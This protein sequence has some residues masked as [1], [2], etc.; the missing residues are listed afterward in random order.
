MEKSRLRQ[1]YQ[2]LT[3]PAIAASPASNATTATTRTYIGELLFRGTTAWPSYTPFE[4]LSRDLSTFQPI[5]LVRRSWGSL[6]WYALALAVS[7]ACLLTFVASTQGLPDEGFALIGLLAA[8]AAL[9]E[10]QPVR[11][12]S[13][14]EMT[15]SVL[16]VLFA[17]VVFGPFAAMV[18]AGLGLL[19]EFRRPYLRWMIWTSLRMLGAGLAGL[20]ASLVLVDE[21]SFERL[22]AAA[23]IATTT[24]ALVDLSLGA[25]TVTI[26]RSGQSAEFI[27]SIRPILLA[28]ICLYTPVIVLLAYAYELSPWSLVLFLG[29]AFAAHRLYG[30]YRQEREATQQLAG[31]YT[32]LEEANLSFASALVAALD[33]RDRYTAGHSAAVAVYARDIARRLGLSDEDQQLAHLSGLLHDIGKVGLPAG[34]L[35]KAGPLTLHERRQMEEH[36]VIGERILS[37]V[38]DYGEIA[39]IVRYHHERIDGNGYPDGLLGA[40]IPVISKIIGVADAYNAMTSGRPYRDAMPSRVARMRLAQA[41]ETQFDTSVV[42]AFEAILASSPESYLSGLHADFAIEAQKHATPTDDPVD[43]AAPSPDPAASSAAA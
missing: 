38:I 32:R 28:T 26:R 27:R 7:S 1:V 9:A 22:V 29:P 6:E 31:A 30:L 13:N 11:V 16:P 36:S 3:A 5:S 39:R 35:E 23:A 18:V 43:P 8:L 40:E 24:E 42:A 10:R 17:A 37:K 14:F 15:V 12:G 41:V 19:V 33:A 4:G 20:T 25:L 21:Y 2:G 34:I